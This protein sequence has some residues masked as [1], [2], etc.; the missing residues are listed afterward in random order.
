LLIKQKSKIHFF[1]CFWV[2]APNEF[3]GLEFAYLA[4]YPRRQVESHGIIFAGFGGALAV[5][6]WPAM[7]H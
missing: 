1:L 5:V 3:N 7:P 2:A 4:G 6:Y